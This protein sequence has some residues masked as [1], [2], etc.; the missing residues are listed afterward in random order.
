MVDEFFISRAIVARYPAAPTTIDDPRIS[1]DNAREFRVAGDRDS[2][3]GFIVDDAGVFRHAQWISGKGPSLGFSTNSLRAVEMTLILLDLAPSLHKGFGVSWRHPSLSGGEL[4][5][6]YTVTSTE[7]STT[8]TWN[9][10]SLWMLEQGTGSWI[11]A[12]AGWLPYTI[13]EIFESRT[14]PPGVVGLVPYRNF[15]RISHDEALRD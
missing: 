14:N 11:R 4:S 1:V 9:E 2:E 12:L 8:V 3:N 5:P 10:G 15:E 13:D 7:D 6:A